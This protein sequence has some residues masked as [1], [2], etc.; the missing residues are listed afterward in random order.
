MGL[1]QMVIRPSDKLDQE[2][3]AHVDLGWMVMWTTEYY[4][5][6]PSGTIK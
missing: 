1:D 2:E 4:I 3:L 5:I 6:R